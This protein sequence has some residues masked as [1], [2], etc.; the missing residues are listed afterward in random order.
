MTQTVPDISPLM[1][2]H[3]DPLLVFFCGCVSDAV[4]PSCAVGFTYIS[5]ESWYLCLLLLCSFMICANNREH[6]GPMVVSGCLH[7][8]LPHYR[9]YADLSEGTKLLKC[10]SDTFCLEWV[11]AIKSILSIIFHAV[12]G[13]VCIQLSHFSYD[14]CEN[15]NTLSCYHN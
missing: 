10:L 4:V 8:T 9:H 5:R 1:P 3:Q 12:Y 11:S 14:V 15:T 2:M 7:I 13:A 6:Y